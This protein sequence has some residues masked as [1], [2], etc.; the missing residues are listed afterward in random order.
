MTDKEFN[1]FIEKA[2]EELKNIDDITKIISLFHGYVKEVV[3][4]DSMHILSI[5]KSNNTAKI[6]EDAGKDTPSYML[7][8]NGIL[9]QCY[10]SHQPLLINDV[11]RSLLYNKEIDSLNEEN[12]QKILVVPILDNDAEKNILGMVWIAIGKGFQQFIQEDLDVL[13][14]FVDAIKHQL[15]FENS[16]SLGEE[17]NAL[18]ICMDSKKVLQAKIERNENYFASTIH[19]IRTPMNAVIGFMELMMRNETDEQKKDYIDATLKSGEHIV[20]LI[21]DAL[22][23]SKVSNGKMSLDK[24]IFSPIDGLSDIAK[25]FYNSMR[26]K[27]INF[28]INIDPLMPALIKTDLHRIK[29]VVN[30]L[31]SNAMKFTPVDGEVVLEAIYSKESDTLKISVN[32]TGIGIAKDKQK[33]IFNPYTQETSSTAK[34][35]GGTG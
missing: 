2:N 32:D 11:N 6:M 28:Y 24:T 26:K 8:Q 33:S 5:D 3:H 31:L 29:Q 34:E 10:A 4:C 17:T 1:N 21:N 35:Y 20:S 14:R 12:I 22:D 18:E 15:S 19:D 13:V 30:N 27:S 9:S 23:M 7:D 25:L 16:S